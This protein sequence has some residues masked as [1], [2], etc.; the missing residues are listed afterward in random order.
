MGKDMIIKILQG[1]LEAANGTILQL[2]MT[3]SDLNVTIN[4][5]NARIA[6]LE[7]LLQERDASLTKAQ[8][9][10]RGLSKLTEKKC[11]R[12]KPQ[13][14]APKTEEERQA[15]QERKAAERKARG[16]NGARRNMHFEMETVFH[17]VYPAGLEGGTPFSTR[18]VIRY[19]MDPQD[20]PT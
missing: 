19:R 13:P 2:N 17:D 6:S 11:E 8:N 5:L 7:A 12:Q 14:P 20:G 18:E 3:V 9:Q 1:Q 15:E 10:I 4:E 16:N